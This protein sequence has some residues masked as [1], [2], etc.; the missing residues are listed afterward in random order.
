MRSRKDLAVEPERLR[1][2]ALLR[3][4]AAALEAM[5]DDNGLARMQSRNRKHPALSQYDMLRRA[6]AQ[7]FVYPDEI[8]MVQSVGRL[9]LNLHP[10]A[11]GREAATFFDF[12]PDQKKRQRLH[13]RLAAPDQYEDVIAE[14][15]T[16]SSLRERGIV[17][18]LAD[19]NGEPDLRL[20]FGRVVW[21]DVKLVRL[22]SNSDRAAAAVSKA[23]EQVRRQSSGPG[24]A[25][26]KITR[27]PVQAALDDRATAD[28]SPYVAQVRRALA[29]GKKFLSHVVVTWDDYLIEGQP[30][31]PTL[32]AF[33]RQSIVVANQ[34]VEAGFDGSA[35]EI[36]RTL[37]LT[38]RWGAR[39]PAQRLDPIV[40]DDVEI[41]EQF[42]IESEAEE[43]VRAGHALEAVRS[44]DAHERVI[45]D[46]SGWAFELFARRVVSRQPHAVLVLATRQT[47]HSR[48]RVAMAFRLFDDVVGR[49]A[50]QLALRQF[51]EHYGEPIEVGGQRGSLIE[52]ATLPVDTDPTQIVRGLS[53][54]ENFL[55][56]LLIRRTESALDVRWAFAIDRGR[57][58]S[59]IRRHRKTH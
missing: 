32:Y 26:L 33:R 54:P 11:V 51:I 18:E 34:T 52:S 1:V 29:R 27:P 2:G 25:F 22:R 3:T 59:D 56:S 7:D 49:A 20:T 4:L 36:G 48:L 35:L 13:A 42:R 55:V 44:H 53:Q 8:P 21:G 6:S 40:E 5:F 58:R 15:S 9:C 14:L 39:R 41:S 17:A 31:D 16:W 43:G 47:E 30:P 10:W 19:E 57:Y 50:P 28:V 37:E 46:E 38:I 12:E 45:L 23:N 24:V